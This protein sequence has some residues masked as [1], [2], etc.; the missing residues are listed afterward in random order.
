MTT[1]TDQFVDIAKKGQEAVTAA[2]QNWAD[3]AQN[4]ATSL[5][6]GQPKLPDAQEIVKSYFDLAEQLLATQRDFAQSVIA[7]ATE[8][9]EAATSAVTDKVVNGKARAAKN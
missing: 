3:N 1:A 8:A 4:F 7:K 9:T 5:T 6:G 2:V